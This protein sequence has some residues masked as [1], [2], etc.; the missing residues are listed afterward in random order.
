L[1]LHP[2]TAY[3]IEAVKKDFDESQIGYPSRALGMFSNTSRE[4]FSHELL[5]ARIGE[6]KKK[7]MGYI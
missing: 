5:N 1:V 3:F 6:K 2:L 4:A 7:K